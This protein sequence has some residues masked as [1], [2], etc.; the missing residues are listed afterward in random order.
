MGVG[1]GSMGVGLGL[2]VPA[3]PKIGVGLVG[4][5]G[6]EI[7]GE[8]VACSFTKACSC[9]FLNSSASFFSCCF[10]RKKSTPSPR[11]MIAIMTLFITPVEK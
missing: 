4:P 11:T 6:E 9:R 3:G 10:C 1:L 2:G 7:V 8:G 5:F